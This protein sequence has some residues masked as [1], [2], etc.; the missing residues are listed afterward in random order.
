MVCIQG[1]QNVDEIE[2][3]QTMKDHHVISVYEEDVPF[4]NAMRS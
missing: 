1:D 4:P 2:I 3:S